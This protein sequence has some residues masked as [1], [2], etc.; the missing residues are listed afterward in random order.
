MA[1]LKE[2]REAAGTYTGYYNI[3]GYYYCMDEN[4]V[5]RLG[6]VV[7]EDG[8]KP[9]TYYFQETPGENGIAGAMLRSQWHY[10]ET[11]K[12]EQWR[13][14]KSDGRLYERG[15]VA[16]RLDT[17]IMGDSKYLLGAA[18]YIQKN[19]MLKAANGY[20][21]ASDENGRVLT[22]TMAKFGSA[23]YYFSSDGRRVKWQN[24]WHSEIARIVFI[25]S[26]IQPEEW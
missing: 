6:D 16:T 18:G 23:R 10:R 26:E 24:C 11:S 8:T 22:N 19:K 13:Y 14:F 25:I 12:G 20:Y 17:E 5:P 9:G 2:I 4:G 21:Y 7:I 1:E 15:I 3:N